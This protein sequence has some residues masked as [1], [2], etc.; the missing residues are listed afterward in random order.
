MGTL[1]AAAAHVEEA[2]IDP[3][4][5]AVGAERPVVCH[6]VER[7]TIGGAQMVLQ[8]LA[9]RLR[10]GAFE[11]IVCGLEGGPLEALLERD[12]IRVVCLDQRRRSVLEGPLYLFYVLRVLKELRRLLRRHKV[13]LIHA[14]LPDAIVVAAIAGRLSGTPVIGTYHGLGILP[15]HRSRYDPRNA[16]RRSLYHLA[17][18]LS[19]RTIAV[20]LPVRE[21]LCHE[22]G[23]SPETTVL[24]Q[25]GIDPERFDKAVAPPGIRREVGIGDREQV[26]VCVG[27]FVVHKGQ[28]VLIEAMAEVVK[29][30]PDAVLVLVGDG[31][32]RQ[33][34]ADLTNRLGLGGS[35]IFAGTRSD[36]P[37][38]LAL[39]KVF[40]LPSFYEGHPLS[41][42][43]AMAA[44]KPVV[45]T[46]VP[47]TSDVIEDGSEGVLVGPG[48]AS[49]MAEAICRLLADSEQAL[50]MGKR[51]QALVRRKYDIRGAASQMEELYQDV[52]RS[53]R[54]VPDR[55]Q[56]QRASE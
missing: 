54:P 27:R 17:G 48:D 32:A 22:L 9:A 16:L 35:V 30:W 13:A 53:E 43:E 47:G 46:R 18:R 44:G 6:L 42:L 25:N 34:V 55:G 39:A 11:H 4:R 21:L 15:K 36:V 50:E 31:P 5:P 24:V 28:R 33:D 7:L 51:G 37:E 19:K 45:A 8:G 10:T 26:I 40:V 41:V 56:L 3:R 1:S 38:I 52:L 49:A 29:R 2:G 12:G 14:H 23:F 20:S